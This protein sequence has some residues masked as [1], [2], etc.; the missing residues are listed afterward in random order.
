MAQNISRDDAR[1]EADDLTTR[2]L[3]AKDAYYGRDTSL[4]DD[5]TYDGWMRRLQELER[6]YP[7]LQGQDSPTQ[8]VGAAEA[9]GLDT[10]EHAE[11]ML[12]LDNVFSLDELREWAGKT[13]AAAG[14]DVAWLTELKIDGLAISLRYEHGVLTSAATRGDG[15][16]GEIVTENALR[17]ADIPAR[18]TGT[19]HPALVEVRGEVF[20]PVAAFERL[21]AAQAEFRDRVYADALDRWAARGGAAKKPFDED[22]ARA[23]AARRFP[24]FANPRNAASGGLRQQL[25]KKEG[26]EHEAGLLRIDSLALYVHGVGAWPDPPVAA[27]SEIYE[28][29]ASWGL[30]TSPHTK[31]C[32]SIDEVDAFVAYF[33]EHRH[34]IEHELD[35]IVVKVDELALHAE[36]GETSRAPRWA[37]AYKYPPEEVQTKLLDIVVSVG[38]TGRATPFAV[39]APAHVAGS[40]VRQATLHNKDVVKAKGVLIGDTVVLRKAGD[41]IPEVLGPVVEL[42]DGTEREF[43]MPERCP[44]CGFVLAPAKEGDIDLRCPNTRSCPAQVR[45]RVEH[46]GSR[47]ALDIEVLGEVTAAAL[48]QAEPPA[49]A[50]LDTEAGLFELTLEELVPISVVVR[51]AETGEPKIDEESG[52]LVRRSPF[53][54]L[55]PAQYPPGTEGMDAA[56]RRR[57]GIRKDYREVLPSEAAV[58][59]LAELEKAKTKELWRLLVALN[60]RHVGP[61]AARALAQW[62]GSL[63]AIRS[64]S[65]EDLAAVDGVGGIIADALRDWFDVDWHRE[66]IERWTAAGVRWATPGHPGPGAAATVGGVLDGVTVVATGS[67]EG[68]TR[69]GAQ[70]AIIAAGGKA[71]SSVSKKT[72]FVAAGPGAGSKLTKA[73]E[74]GVR[75][76]D[77]AQFK[78]LVEQGP[79]ALDA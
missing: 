25:D 7:E 52:E 24:S 17:L 76:I 37:I 38:R 72:D 53:Q 59:L 44:E 31:V 27:Q 6:L 77:A 49:V 8:M 35:G 34:D 16:V 75:I 4:V 50:P 65:Q 48:T 26:L 30:P 43:V 2:I 62:F 41:V 71:A 1:A 5:A 39:M 64:A 28:L 73:E 51:D 79:G 13:R 67:L 19:D 63:D 61:V 21:N 58:K 70:E 11:R 66:I 3:D 68:Y 55:G 45:G 36:L 9:T 18:L 22:K 56:A 78:V 60:I 40:V 23:A 29:M 74:L 69:E 32:R 46:I 57:A 20:I 47:G 54:K 10:I 42:R 14:R 33:G 12:S 15:R